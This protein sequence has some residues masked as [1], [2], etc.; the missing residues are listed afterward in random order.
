MLFITDLLDTNNIR[1]LCIVPYLNYHNMSPP[2]HNGPH[3]RARIL[4]W[5]QIWTPSR[6]W[7]I[8]LKHRNLHENGI[9]Q[10]FVSQILQSIPESKVHGANVGPT[11]GRQDPG[12]PHVGHMNFVI[13][14]MAPIYKAFRDNDGVYFSYFTCRQSIDYLVFFIRRRAYIHFSNMFCFPENRYIW[15]HTF[16]RM[17]LIF[18]CVFHQG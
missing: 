3:M 4:K 9:N 12:G 13:W 17:L 5:C 10:S 16:N 14:D 11:W 8:L 1:A 7:H 6:T 15:S 2:N 18:R